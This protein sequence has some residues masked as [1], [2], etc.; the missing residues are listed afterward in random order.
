MFSRLTPVT[1]TLIIANVVVFLFQSSTGDV[2]FEH[3]ALWPLTS[4][5]S[6]GAPTFQPW[7]LVSYAFL[8]GGTGHLFFNMLAL[9]MFGSDIERVFGRNRFIAYYLACVISAA[10][11]QLLVAIV[12]GAQPYPTV[13]ASGGI[14][15]ILL[16]FGMFYP[17]RR[18]LLLIPPI[19]MP[20]WLFVTLY[21]VVELAMGVTGFDS[22]VAHFAHL[23]GMAGGYMLIRVWRNSRRR[24]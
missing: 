24:M 4:D 10:V 9:Y 17:Q 20:A 1:L 13:G 22:S 15:G 8:H 5:T 14:F 7:Q 19:P 12:T 23:G 18:I 2:L 11:A 3:F 6:Y 21:G 16:A